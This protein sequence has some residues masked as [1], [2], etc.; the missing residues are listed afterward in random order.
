[1]AGPV[2]DLELRKAFQELQMKMIETT[3]RLKM[4]DIQVEQC[5]RQINHAK[6]TN[7]EISEIPTDTRTYESVGRMFILTPVNIVQDD[8]Q[9][10]IKSQEEK[11]KNLESNKSYLE[12]CIKESEDNLRELIVTKKSK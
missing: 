1:M 10:K 5:R 7:R 9:L 4:S 8:L 11:I 3:Q 6:L 12:K 2:V